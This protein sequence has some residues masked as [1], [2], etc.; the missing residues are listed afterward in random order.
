MFYEIDGV[1][2]RGA[3]LPIELLPD[4]SWRIEDAGVCVWFVKQRTIDALVAVGMIT[5]PAGSPLQ[6]TLTA[7]GT[8]FAAANPI[9]YDG[10]A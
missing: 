8:T 4:V 1:T 10:M 6:S 5:T 7:A 2:P 9:F 3:P